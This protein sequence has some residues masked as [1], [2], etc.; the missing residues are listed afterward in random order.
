MRTAVPRPLNEVRR[1][2]GG[3]EGEKAGIWFRVDS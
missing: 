2:L 3:G 1:S